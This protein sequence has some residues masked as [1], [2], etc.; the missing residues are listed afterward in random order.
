MTT[1]STERIP[2]NASHATSWLLITTCAYG[3]AIEF[4]D[5]FWRSVGTAEEG[6]GASK[7]AAIGASWGLLAFLL[8]VTAF[9]GYRA[10]EGLLWGPFGL[11]VLF[12]MAVTFRGDFIRTGTFDFF[13][14]PKTWLAPMVLACTVGWVLAIGLRLAFKCPVLAGKNLAKTE[15][16][17]LMLL[18]CAVTLSWI[19]N[20]LSPI[21]AWSQFAPTRH[22]ALL[23]I[24]VFL[25]ILW[26][27]P[28]N[29]NADE[30]S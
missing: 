25:A 6:S 5:F 10:K 11:Y 4:S 3:S 22:Y 14:E 24:W 16:A 21:T 27:I 2:D 7:L 9:I 28:R 18:G 1:V 17:S 12:F 23:I 26:F 29:R 13:E 15:V 30:Y 8:A 19:V 20:F